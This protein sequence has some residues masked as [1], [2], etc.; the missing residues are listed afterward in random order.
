VLVVRKLGVPGHD[1]LAMGAI[2]PGG[3]RVLNDEVIRDLRS[4]PLSTQSARTSLPAAAIEGAGEWGSGSL[5]TGRM[6]EP[7][8]QA[9]ALFAP[10][11]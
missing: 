11:R 5:V 8:A 10:L 9:F 7:Y 4:L 2:A 6:S 1:E 3:V